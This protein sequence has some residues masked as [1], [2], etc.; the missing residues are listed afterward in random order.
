MNQSQAE[1]KMNPGNRRV[2]SACSILL[3]CLSC[4]GMSTLAA[5]QPGESDAG[6]IE[7]QQNG[8]TLW[9]KLQSTGLTGFVLFVISVFGL[10][11]LMERFFN[12]RQYRIVPAGLVEEAHQLWREKKYDEMLQWGKNHNSTLARAIQMIVENRK[13][14]KTEVAEMVSDLSSREIKQHLHRAYPLAIVATVSP[15]LGLMG[16]VFGMIGAFDAVAHAKTMGDP[17]IMAESISFALMTTAMG[18]VI[19]VPALAAY[20]FF[21]IRTNMLALVLEDRVTDIMNLWFQKREIRDASQ[22]G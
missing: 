16:T 1:V 18:L 9:D 13:A 11:F 10:S 6:Q 21:R 7:E 2:I 17:S 14:D 12:L 19:A 22:D 5:A 8:T 4:L 15:L 20:H 3:L